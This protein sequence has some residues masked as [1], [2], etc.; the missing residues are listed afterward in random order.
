VGDINNL[1]FNRERLCLITNRFFGHH[2]MNSAD[3][4]ATDDGRFAFEDKLPPIVRRLEEHKN[5]RGRAPPVCVIVVGMAGSGKTTLMAQLQRDLE[6]RQQKEE[7]EQ[8]AREGD[9]RK[10]PPVTVCTPD[11]QTLNS[12][13]SVEPAS[14]PPRKYYCVNLDPA[15]LHV[16]Y[17]VSIDIRDT[18]DYKQVMQQH[19]LG[20]NGAIMTS[21][22]LFA[23]KFDQVI[24]ILEQRGYPDEVADNRPSDAT[25]APPSE[26]TDTVPLNG[27]P[28]L[29]SKA[30]DY[31]LV[32]TPGQIE[33]F[34]WSASGTIFTEAL[35]SA[36]P[37]VLCFV[38][39]TVRCASSPNTFM[40]NMLYACSMY[41][42]TR[43][44]IVVCFN[45]TDVVSHLFCEEWMRDYE[46]FQQALDDVGTSDS[47]VDAVDPTSSGTGAGFYGS[48]T[49]SLS[50]V[51]D[52]FYSGFV[53]SVGVSA[54]TGDG[55]D[56]FWETVSRAAS[57]DF[58]TDYIQDLRD[59]VEEQHVRQ[60]AM[61]RIQARRLRKDIENE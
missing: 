47:S 10:P 60:R 23:T 19:K 58:V 20:P 5:G 46:A 44:P 2:K 21:L 28:K 3:K 12:E 53:H 29:Q 9:T 55:M 51:L 22:N 13:Q 57:T 34:T 38:V 48:L 50:L 8:Q 18:V 30:M 16:P 54:V 11:V 27:D 43:L 37:V 25:E 26:A 52:E 31:I 36:F 42:R 15:T 39:D 41:Y 24:R 56:Q 33:A 35:A 32:D 59:R 6:Q 17:D 61:A 4:D 45:K 49:R 40:S 1:V 14:P 7:Q